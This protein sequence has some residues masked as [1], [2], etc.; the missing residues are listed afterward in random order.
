M[1]K[2]FCSSSEALNSD[3]NVTAMTM[4][5]NKASKV[6]IRLAL[7]TN[8]DSLAQTS[9]KGG[10]QSSMPSAPDILANAMGTA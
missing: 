9:G 5:D 3:P 4:A 7:M 2:K 8:F 1:L 10:A 6:T